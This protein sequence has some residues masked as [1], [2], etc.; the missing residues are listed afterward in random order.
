MSK[1][2]LSSGQPLEAM[3]TLIK[4]MIEHMLGP[5][6]VVTLVTVASYAIYQ[7]QA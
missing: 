1:F 2:E 4:F 5:A 7:P 6:F 3:T